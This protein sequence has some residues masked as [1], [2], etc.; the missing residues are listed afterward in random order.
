MRYAPPPEGTYATVAD[1]PMTT[2]PQLNHPEVAQL[3]VSQPAVF[4]PPNAGPTPSSIPVS[5]SI[6][7][8]ALSGSPADMMPNTGTYTFKELQ[9]HWFY[10]ENVELRQIWKPYSIIDSIKLENASMSGMYEIYI[11]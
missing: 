5:G 6:P 3:P 8:P 10:C 1:I 4:Q 7:A 2:S 11:N 9:H